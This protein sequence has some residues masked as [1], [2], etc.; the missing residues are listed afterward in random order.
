LR[1][2]VANIHHSGAGM[3]PSSTSPTLDFKT[4]TFRNHNPDM[5]S[6][7]SA[8]LSSAKQLNSQSSM[9]DDAPKSPFDGLL[10]RLRRVAEF[11]SLIKEVS[12]IS[13]KSASTVYP[14]MG[15]IP[16]ASMNESLRSP[17]LRDLEIIGYEGYI[18]SICLTAHPLAIYRHKFA[19]KACPVRTFHSCSVERLIEVQKERQEEH[20]WPQQ[21]ERVKEDTAGTY[22]HELIKA[23]T[24]EVKKWTKGI[25]LLMARTIHFRNRLFDDLIVVS[26]KE[27]KDRA[28][29]KGFTFLTDEELADFIE[30]AGNNTFGLFKVE[31][32]DR[33]SHTADVLYFMYLVKG[34]ESP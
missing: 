22:Q 19:P 16:Q 1:R 18:C 28:I 2:H 23:I 17:S 33:N 14:D 25:P 34:T 20:Q 24:L 9:Q 27:W 13:S 32:A 5:P 26:E 4:A 10:A 31:Q 11:K 21:D 30:L 8:I 15:A 29:R 12:P 3:Q 6:D 7:V